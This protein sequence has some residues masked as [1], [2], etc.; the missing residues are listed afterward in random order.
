MHK[1]DYRTIEVEIAQILGKD[2][3]SSSPETKV[4]HSYDA[5]R[6][7]G[8]PDLICWPESAAEVSAVVKVAASHKAPIV[9]R[10]AASGLT[11]GAVPEA[12]GLVIDFLK[13]NRI[14]TIDA[15]SGYA[16]IEPGVL[17]DDFQA[18]LALIRI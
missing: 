15:V 7:R 6:L 4:T 18:A 2:R 8:K 16:T 17:I 11:G 10:G 3:V 9:A 14:A 5:S 12:G 1:P 13:M